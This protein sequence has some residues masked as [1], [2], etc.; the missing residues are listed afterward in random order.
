MTRDEMEAAVLACPSHLY[1]YSPSG[2]STD[3]RWV[4][5]EGSFNTLERAYMHTLE[6]TKEG[7]DAR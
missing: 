7:T 5:T 4:F 1:T 3:V 2:T 6:V